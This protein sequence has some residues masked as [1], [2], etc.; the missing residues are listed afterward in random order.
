M[1]RG[2]LEKLLEWTRAVFDGTV[3]REDLKHLS[4]HTRVFVGTAIM[5]LQHDDYISSQGDLKDPYGESLSYLTQGSIRD[6][7]STYDFGTAQELR[8]AAQRMGFYKPTPGRGDLKQISLQ[9][10]P[11]LTALVAELGCTDAIEIFLQQAAAQACVEVMEA[12]MGAAQLP[13]PLAFTHGRHTHLD[14]II[15]DVMSRYGRTG[16]SE[17]LTKINEQL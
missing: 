16:L 6:Y 5:W 11:E 10:P 9:L 13:R 1:R 7:A 15:E 2:E 3:S 4:K 12:R 8:V 14:G 17:L